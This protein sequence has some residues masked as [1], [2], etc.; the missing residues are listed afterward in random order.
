VIPFYEN[1]LG[2]VLYKWERPMEYW[3]VH[4]GDTSKPGI[5]GRL[6]RPSDQLSGTVNTVDIDNL[7]E[8][9]AK[10]RQD[11]GKVIAGKHAVPGVGW[12]ACCQDPEGNVFGMMQDDPK[13]GMSGS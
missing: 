13:A 10:V 12:L 11:G 4:T 8:A 7:D 6:S 9:L 5:D 2:W 1:V 3:L